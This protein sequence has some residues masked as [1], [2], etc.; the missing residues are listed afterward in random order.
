M[1][2]AHSSLCERGR[3][4]PSPPPRVGECESCWYCRVRFPP[5]F[6][7][8]DCASC[9][10]S[11]V[12]VCVSVFVLL[13]LPFSSFSAAGCVLRAWSMMARRISGW[14]WMLFGGLVA[15]TVCKYL[16]GKKCQSGVLVCVCA[17]ACLKECGVCRRCCGWQQS[18]QING[19]LILQRCFMHYMLL[20][21]V[22]C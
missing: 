13:L 10:S 21:R 9:N 17:C 12:C 8:H 6:V 16:C 5:L 19:C 2:C 22:G 20:L 11:D 4:A 18:K 3:P 1:W 14:C 15:L 7:R